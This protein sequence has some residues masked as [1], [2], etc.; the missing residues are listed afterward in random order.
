MSETNARPFKGRLGFDANNEK[1]SN[2]ADPIQPQDVVNQRYFIA[3]NTVSIFDTT[4]TYPAGFIVE[5]SDR[6]Y[7][8]KANIDQGPFDLT[9][10]T[11]IHAFGRWLRITNNYTAEPGDNLFVSTATASVTVTLPLP[12]E[13]GDIVTILDEGS[14]KTNPISLNA[15]TNTINGSGSSYEINSQDIVQLIYVGGTWKVSREEKT[16]FQYLTANATVAPN[17]FNLVQTTAART[18]TLPP[19]PVAGQ[20][21]V[22]AD[23]NSMASNYPIT[24][25]GNGKTINGSASYVVKRYSEQVTMVFDGT[26]WKAVSNAINRILETLTPVIGQ[27]VSVGL[28]ATNKAMTLPATGLVNGDWVEVITTLDD[29]IATGSLVVTAGSQTFRIKRRGRTLFLYKGTWSI[30]ALEDG[31]I[32]APAIN[33]GTMAKNSMVVLSGSASNTIYLP[34]G[35]SLQ[36]GDYVTTKINS[37]AGRVLVSV[38]NT[39]TDLIDATTTKTFAVGDTGVMVTFVYRGY[40]GSKYVWES[41]DH[42]S[43]YLKK[44][45]NLGDLPDKAAAR[46]NLD[47]F[48][49]TET[50]QNF[51]GINAKAKDS[52]KAD[53]ADKLDG[54]DSTDFIRVKNGVTTAVDANTTAETRFTTN[55]NT[56]NTTEMWQVVMFVDAASGDKCQIAMGKTT[57]KI[58]YRAFSG[59]AWVGWTMLDQSANAATAS[60]LATA[61]TVALT[62]DVTGSG[63][64]DGSSNMTITATVESANVN[65]EDLTASYSSIKSGVFADKIGN[66]TRILAK[67]A[68]GSGLIV[69]I[70]NSTGNGTVSYW[71]G[72]VWV[73]NRLYTDSYKPTADKWTTPRKITFTG[74]VVGEVTL[75]GSGDVVLES[76]ISVG[77]TQF[78]INNVNGL[79]DALNAKL[80]S[81]ATAVDSAKLGGV[82]ASNYRMSIAPTNATEDPNTTVEDLILTNHANTP[83][84]TSYWY[85]ESTFYQTRAT[86]S[87]RFQIASKYNGG[88][89]IAFRQYYNG[90]WSS[91]ISMT[92]KV[93]KVA[94]KGLST[95]DY[96]TTEKTKLA[97]IENNAT[98]DQ[99]PTEILTAVKTVDGSGSGLDADLLD[100]K[101]ASDFA[102]ATQGAK[103]D[104]AVQPSALGSAA[105][106]D[107]PATGNATTTQVVLGNDT[108]LSNA[109]TPTTHTHTIS[110]VTG[111]Q[112]ALDGK[113]GVLGF[114][115]ENV[116]NKG[117]A[118]GYAG[119]D[120][121][122]K[123]PASQLP[124]FV[125]DVVEY[126]SSANFPSTGETGKIYIAIDS[127]KTYRWSGSAYI[128]INSSVGSADTATKLATPRT[129]ALSGDVTGSGTF[130]GSSNM[131]ITATVSDDS[132]N[133][134]ISN[135]DGLQTALDGKVD[136]VQQSRFSPN[137]API[138]IVLGQ[139]NAYG[140]G[141][142]GNN[143]TFT[144]TKMMDKGLITSA[145]LDLQSLKDHQNLWINQTT[146]GVANLAVV[147]S[148]LGDQSGC[149]NV[150]TEFAKRW[151][152]N[153]DSLGL[154]DLYTIIVAEGSQGMRYGSGS[155]IDHWSP[156][157]SNLDNTSHY[158]RS[159]K[160]IRLAMDN[161]RSLGKNPQ[162]IA[163]HWNQWEAEAEA[164][165]AL[166][167]TATLSNLTKIY[168]GI[169]A[170]IGHPVPWRVYYPRSIEYSGWAAGAFD[171][172][173]ESISAFADNNP[174]VEIIDPLE[175]SPIYDTVFGGDNIH[176][177]SGTQDFFA[178]IEWLMSVSAIGN[179]TRP[180]RV[181][182]D[183]VLLGAGTRIR[184][185]FSNSQES[186]R[187]AFQTSI[188]NSH[189][190]LTVI[191]SGTG[192]TSGVVLYSSSDPDNASYLLVGSGDTG[193]AIRTSKNGS[194]AAVGLSILAD[195]DGGGIYIDP[196]GNI[197]I[198]K[199]CTAEGFTKLG[200]DAPAV[201]HKLYT[202]TTAG[203]QGGI[204]TISHTL[205]SSKI[206]S[207][208]LMVDCQNTAAGMFVP[209]GWNGNGVGGYRA[210]VTI[211]SDGFRIFNETNASSAILNRPFKLFVTYQE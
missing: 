18:I 41:I 127:G 176:Y 86:G 24:I 156:E 180:D 37:A 197:N 36:V 84:G 189:T 155:S 129:I 13:D 160:L 122:G 50:T 139:S 61:R 211:D 175:F 35:D 21:V 8:A 144:R 204:T 6:L 38:Q 34:S 123:V 195:V 43:A 201:K 62:G 100:G 27:T 166:S 68:A 52:D 191:P 164:L 17:S 30:I 210:W 209:Q 16:T 49:T 154:P 44:S 19:V 88:S 22:V 29:E 80:D 53:N 3:N 82:V 99:T 131:T 161:L 10:W 25:Q 115:P 47:V 60:K 202:G 55:V 130:D 136:L 95:E 79:Q 12:A 59:S 179:G 118:N 119:L 126:A 168:G 7:K 124:S 194:G 163:I 81:N 158:W 70:D 121:S 51:L 208:D 103:A 75:D 182:S 151:Q 71:N 205:N 141:T 187:G 32:S 198:K 48:S 31:G 120:T 153:A 63:T 106:K 181:H 83:D 89:D 116:S 105:A 206:L 76:T 112:T 90:V 94:G 171:K 107:V 147:G 5:Y 72:T 184:G 148:G 26:E 85:I 188:P 149:Y 97:G 65:L 74:G 200:M 114:T 133:H 137:D 111:L 193:A 178:R 87:N 186:L 40:N 113:Q 143:A 117:V 23:A 20:W 145:G 98:A 39:S 46:D 77:A 96:T 101:H 58:A 108:R 172:V 93:D 128:H 196:P 73:S 110:S 190:A 169:N 162:I 146:N 135:V 150:A 159:R 57:S 11:E 66:V 33:T 174:N 56:P 152:A 45:E 67:D 102:T 138:L 132:H 142:S 203:T 64:F 157:R 104:S 2:V 185:D 9:K 15:G 167:A 28:D 170:E 177:T 192:T 183:L 125:D 54:L 69:D 78:E 42:G 92:N 4:R 140:H 109:R 199:T 14:A 91:W 165:D 173:V 207:V 1:V 134:T